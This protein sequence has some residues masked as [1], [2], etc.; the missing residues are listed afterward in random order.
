LYLL[1][2]FYF[3]ISS[4]LLW[5]VSTGGVRTDKLLAEYDRFSNELLKLWKL[6][7]THNL[8]AKNRFV[9]VELTI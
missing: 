8:C 9:Q 5:V 7:G 1:L 3:L 6:F 2:P 4:F